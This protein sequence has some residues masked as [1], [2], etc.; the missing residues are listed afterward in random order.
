MPQIFD[1]VEELRLVDW[2]TIVIYTCINTDCLPEKDSFYE[3]EFAYI[4]ISDDF[5]HVRY[6]DESQIQEQK[7]HKMKLMEEM[8]AEMLKN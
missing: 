4:Q 3:E 7:K 6:G 5:Q 1:K 2:E 8:E